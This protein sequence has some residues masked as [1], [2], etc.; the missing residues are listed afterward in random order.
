MLS[1]VDAHGEHDP[2]MRRGRPLQLEPG[3]LGALRSLCLC[4]GNGLESTVSPTRNSAETVIYCSYYYQARAAG[5]GGDE[6]VVVARVV[7]TA[8]L[9]FQSNKAYLRVSLS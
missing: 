5:R 2:G 4:L 6:D 1:Y 8:M 7:E 3:Q 9:L